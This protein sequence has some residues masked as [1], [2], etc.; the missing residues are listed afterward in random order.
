MVRP[1]SASNVPNDPAI[2]GGVP[3]VNI[4][5]FDA[6]GRRLDAAVPDPAVMEPARD[7][8]PQ[9]RR[10]FHQVRRR[11]PPRADPINDL[12]ATIGRMNF[13][14][15]FTNRAVGDLLLGLPSQLALTSYTV[16]DQGQDMQFYFVQD[17][18]RISTKLTANVG[19][20]TSTPRLRASGTTSSPTSIRRPGR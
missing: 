11:V 18:Y 19:L 4:Q 5:G 2:M 9:S 1:R 15:R 16:M 8:Q 17:D 7:V 12:N 6:V 14:N 10:A 13:E 3:K 20:R